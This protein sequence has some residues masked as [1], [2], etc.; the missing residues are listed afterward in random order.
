MYWQGV[1]ERLSIPGLCLLAAGAV[2]GYGAKWLAAKLPWLGGERAV[3]PVK[4]AGLVLALAVALIL[5][6]IIPI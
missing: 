6:D 3:V 2:L 5:L 4:V 1:L